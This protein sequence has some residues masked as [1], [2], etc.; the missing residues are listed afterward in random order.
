MAIHIKHRFIER[1]TPSKE[2]NLI[3]TIVIGTFNPGLP[4]IN[5]L[6]NSEK[7]QFDEI[8]K[9]EK[10]NKFNRVKNFYDRGPNRFWGIMDRI[11]NPDFYIK[12]GLEAKN[13]NGLKC[14]VGSFREETF[15]RQKLFCIKAGLFITDF[16]K[17][18]RPASFD[19]IYDN[20][21]DKQIEN[22]NPEW[23]TDDIIRI[24]FKHRPTKVI[25]NFSINKKSIPKIS[26]QA[27]KIKNSFPDITC[28]AASTS[29]AAGNTY[30][31]LLNEWKQLIFYE[32]K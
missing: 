15:Q 8:E 12:N 1:L 17:S 31:L 13:T 28:S 19:K 21:P 9:S 6:S 26:E 3:N 27:L 23:H 2:F 20:F 22:S 10:F 11:Y 32:A 29:G 4:E 24:I 30:E 5:I 7:A 18:I 14:F 16:V 25:L